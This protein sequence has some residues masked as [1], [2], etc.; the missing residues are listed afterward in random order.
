MKRVGG[1]RRIKIEISRPKNNE[2]LNKG[3]KI[4]GVHSRINTN[5]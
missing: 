5:N 1:G 4:K 3:I 2:G